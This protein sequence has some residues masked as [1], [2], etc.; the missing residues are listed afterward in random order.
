[1]GRQG[2]AGLVYVEK[3]QLGGPQNYYYEHIIVSHL[4][5]VHGVQVGGKNLPLANKQVFLSR[6]PS[7][8]IEVTR[9]LPFGL[10]SP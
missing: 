6:Y 5:N 1:M 9:H 2:R 8:Y 10:G 4:F 7:F 3:I